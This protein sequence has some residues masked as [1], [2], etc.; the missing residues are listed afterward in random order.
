MNKF[1]DGPLAV[2]EFSRYSLRSKVFSYPRYPA[3]NPMEDSKLLS[4]T[5]T[6]GGFAVR[7]ACLFS[8]C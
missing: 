2:G 4:A 3:S 7:E 6:P 5:R 1:G 8:N